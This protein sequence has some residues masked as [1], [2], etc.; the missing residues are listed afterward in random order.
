MRLDALS[1][2]RWVLLALLTC[3]AACASSEP[4]PLSTRPQSVELAKERVSVPLRLRAN[5][6]VVMA[7]INGGGPYPFIVDSGSAVTVISERVA[8]ATGLEGRSIELNIVGAESTETRV[9]DFCRVA[10][11]DIGGFRVTGFDA[12][13]LPLGQ[14]RATVPGGVEGL[15]NLELFGDHVVTVDYPARGFIVERTTLPATDEQETFEVAYREGI[16][17]LATSVGETVIPLT[18]DT[19][20][21]EFV[22]IPE[23]R[24]GDVTFA[25]GPVDGSL[26]TTVTGRH[27]NQLGR[28]AGDLALGAH[29]VAR[30]IVSLTSQDGRMGG[31]FLSRFRL[32]FDRTRQRIRFSRSS[33]DLIEIPPL[34]SA[35][36]AFEVAGLGWRIFDVI[37]GTPAAALGL[38]AGDVV[39]EVQGIPVQEVDEGAWRI[40]VSGKEDIRVAVLRD[41]RRRDLVLEVFDLVP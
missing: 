11:L 17:V 40:L 8:T 39:V 3:L 30:P 34:R 29:R 5:V 27:R 6:P 33:S 41:G 1:S 26:S 12:C 13:V 24:M 23:S 2:M 21:G 4:V 31:A 14:I 19:G 16:P 35:G 32:S 36:V 18:I 25:H 20:S 7:R 22:A 10:S 28:L 37:P 15:L 9:V 38:A